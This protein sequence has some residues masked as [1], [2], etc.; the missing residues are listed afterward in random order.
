MSQFNNDLVAGVQQ[1]IEHH[2]NGN[3]EEAILHY[4]NV[5]PRLAGKT[6]ASLSGNVGALYMSKGEYEKAKSHFVASVEA[7]PENPSAHFNLAVVLTTKLGEHAKAIKHCGIALKL[8]KTNHKALHLMGNIMQ[9]IGRPEE[10]SK[11]FVA[12]ES[13]ALQTQE[14]SQAKVIGDSSSKHPLEQ[15]N[16]FK[17]ETGDIIQSVI[18]GREY[19]LECISEQP[20]VFIIDN[21]IDERDC[22]HIITRASKLLEKSFVMGGEYSAVSGGAQQG[23]EDPSALSR[24]DEGSVDPALYRSSYNAWLSQ[25]GVL[26]ELQQRLASVLGFPAPYLKHKSEELQVVRY[27]PGGQ[28]KVHQDSSTFNSRL[29][30]ALLYL[31]TAV[32]S[33]AD[34]DECTVRGGETWFPYAPPATDMAA[35]AITTTTADNDMQPL[36]E[37]SSLVCPGTVEGAIEKALSVYEAHKALTTEAIRAPCL[38]GRK[39]AP[40]R[41]SAV[42]FFNHLASGDIDPSA[43]HAGLPVQVKHVA[44]HSGS[45][46][47]GQE[48]HS[49]AA[50][51]EKWV[52]N[53]WVELDAE[54][55]AQYLK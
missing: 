30:T 34:A 35:I 1:A 43:V 48:P 15:L 12:A 36:V 11:Y 9:S 22:E 13:N 46:G 50:N 41:G 3:I 27:G 2:K 37:G 52:A 23:D 45:D 38:P 33:G 32:Q 49:T 5:L 44:P 17:A 53:Y 47:T 54:L 20:R 24:P 21:L 8:D 10:A 25:D 55:L 29:F 4:E 14:E 26:N 7:D 6:K 40:K 39:I 31:N 42:I 16:V 51:I 19:S 18:D 28:F